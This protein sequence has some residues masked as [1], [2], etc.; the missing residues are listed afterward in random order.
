MAGDDQST[1]AGIAPAG[2]LDL[3]GL[4]S[5]L[6]VG[7]LRTIAILVGGAAGALARAGLAEAWPNHGAWP[8]PTF[9]VNLCGAAILG[10]LVTRL[11]EQVAPT[12]LWR[13]FLGTGLC[14]ALT[15]YSTFQVETIRLAKHGHLG[16]AVEYV[17]VSLVLGM[18][19]AVGGSVLARQHRYR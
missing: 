4:N 16:L 12:R 8:W 11:S 9:I 18:V 19:L 5:G 2:T 10:W 14:G 13:P 15:T 7:Q 1:V 17:L 6:S 3:S